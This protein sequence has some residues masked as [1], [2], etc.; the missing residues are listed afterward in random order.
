[1][2]GWRLWVE[3]IRA[4]R[5]RLGEWREDYVW[6]VGGWVMVGARTRWVVVPHD[7]N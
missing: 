3:R 1:M 6:W 2:N 7:A 4:E 5:A